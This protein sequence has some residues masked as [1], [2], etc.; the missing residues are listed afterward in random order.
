MLVLASKSPRRAELLEQIGVAFIAISVDIDESVR[1]S[2]PVQHYV[3]RLAEEKAKAGFQLSSGRPSLGSDTAV[4]CQGS[5]FGKPQDKADAMRMLKRMSGDWHDVYTAVAIYDGQKLKSLCVRSSVRF[6]ELHDSEC[7]A[8][9]Q[10]GE[11]A[12]KA[13]A[14]GIQGKGAVFV[15]ELKGS[16]SG[17]MGLP[18][19][20]TAS[21]VA[22]FGLP[23]WIHL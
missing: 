16:Y 23:V 5:I 9:W 10:T 1:P 6:R 17:V 18:L 20:E 3:L 15:Q 14:Y 19:C 2:E 22:E 21:L 11:P 8:Y 12:D 4:Y 13:G 7:E